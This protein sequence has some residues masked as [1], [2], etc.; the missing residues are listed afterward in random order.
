MYVVGQYPAFLQS[1][2][3]F[4]KTV[5]KKLNEFMK[6]RH[7]GVQDMACETFLK[8]CIKCKEEYLKVQTGEKE[9]FIYEIIRNMEID[10][11]L[12]EDKQKLVFYEAVGHII[13]AEKEDT[14]REIYLYNL[15]A[16]WDNKWKEVMIEASKNAT[17]LESQDIIRV[18]DLII[19]I[20]QSVGGAV[21]NIYCTYLQS[22]YMDMLN[23]Y[24][25]YSTLISQQLAHA[26]GAHTQIIKQLR[27]LRKNILK[28]VAIF[29]R[30]STDH[31]MLAQNFVPH[32][33]Q[34]IGDYKDNMPDARDPEVISLFATLVTKLK[35]N[36]ETDIANLLI[37]LGQPTLDM[38]Q[39]NYQCYPEHREN[40]FDLLKA[41]TENC[42]P[43]LIL[44][45][46]QLFKT[47]IDSIIWEFKH[48]TPLLAEIGLETMITL[49]DVIYIYIYNILNI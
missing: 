36:M 24:K 16:P 34:F 15:M 7:P 42:F 8:V 18:I 45:D 29:V 38:I 10:G 1:H 48:E 12:L 40:F 17:Y 26:I 20:N 44:L 25:Y 49:L 23:V 6:E 43:A 39:N 14:K 35:N 27:T 22:L 4:L 31:V 3:K 32:L 19:R 11:A 21:G 2:W 5:I 41:I 13:C 9:S 46:S 47:F 28:L 37:S 33:A 30:N